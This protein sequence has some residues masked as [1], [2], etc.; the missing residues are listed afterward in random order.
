MSWLRRSRLAL[1]SVLCVLPPSEWSEVYSRR[2]SVAVIG[3]CLGFLLQHQHLE[4]LWHRRSRRVWV[5]YMLD[6][7]GNSV[8]ATVFT[9]DGGMATAVRVK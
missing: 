3:T 4:V 8:G 7:S 6:N 1:G 2:S 5:L 9:S